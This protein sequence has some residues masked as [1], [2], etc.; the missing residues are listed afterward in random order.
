MTPA[1]SVTRTSVPSP[2][3]YTYDGTGWTTQTVYTAANTKSADQKDH[4]TFY[5][6]YK[7]YEG[8]TWTE[9]TALTEDDDGQL[10]LI[11]AIT[12]LQKEDSSGE[13]TEA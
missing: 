12:A 2:A 13:A 10:K 5:Y 7:P 3:V 11:Q 8:S 1:I 6:S 9:W 4:V